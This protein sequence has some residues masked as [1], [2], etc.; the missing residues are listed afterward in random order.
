MTTETIQVSTARAKRDFSQL[1]NQ[2]F[3]GN[4]RVVVTS[5]GKPKVAI[6]TLK[7]ADSKVGAWKQKRLKALHT[8]DQHYARLR[9]KAKGK[10][11]DPVEILHHLRDERDQ[12]LLAG[13]R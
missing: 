6:V 1:V 13:L 2:V 5:R 9:Q 11:P 10:L 4:Q 7:Q 12:H 3:F 8:L